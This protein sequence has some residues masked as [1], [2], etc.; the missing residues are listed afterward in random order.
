MG[1]HEFSPEVVEFRAVRTFPARDGSGNYAHISPYVGWEYYEC[2]LN[3]VFGAGK[4]S[5]AFE[6]VNFD[7]GVDENGRAR[8]FATVLARLVL[9]DGRTISALGP[10]H[11]GDYTMTIKAAQTAAMK[12]VCALAGIGVALYAMTDVYVKLDERGR[13]SDQEIERLRGLYRKVVDG[14]R[15]RSVLYGGGQHAAPSPPKQQ[16]AGGRSGR[17]HE[18][19]QPAVVEAFEDTAGELF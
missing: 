2:A 9:P 11:S 19:A 4:W 10:H 12:K 3:E 1:T 18:P 16:H 17:S 14:I 8:Y 7:S 15:G 6:L 5:I 13:I